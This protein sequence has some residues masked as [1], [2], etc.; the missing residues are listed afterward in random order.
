MKLALTL[1]TITLLATF[2]GA[3]TVDFNSYSPLDVCTNSVSTGGLD[4]NSGVDCIGSYM[5][6]WDGSSPNG[7]GTPALIFAGFGSGNSMTM[8]LTGGGSFTLNSVDMTISWYDANPME[9]IMV[10]G[11]TPIMLMQGL[12]TYPLNLTGTSF[13]FSDLPSGSAI[14]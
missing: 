14:G 8:S 3:A 4:F 5:Y 10:N 6:V 9:T 2:A 12:M 7:N 1:V 13:T 11:S